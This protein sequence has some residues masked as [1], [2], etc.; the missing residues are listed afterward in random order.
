VKTKL[1]LSVKDVGRILL[2]YLNQKYNQQIK[3][4]PKDI[5]FQLKLDDNLYVADC[6]TGNGII[7]G[8]EVEYEDFPESDI[9]PKLVPFFKSTL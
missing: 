8:V 6:E 1:Q 5:K 9:D 7:Q 3:V 4:T 2:L